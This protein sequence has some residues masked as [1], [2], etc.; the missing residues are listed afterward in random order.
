MSARASGI[1]EQW[2]EA[3]HPSEHGDVID[4]DPTLGQQL[5]DIAIGEPVAEIPPQ[6]ENDD[7]GREPEPSKRRP[8]ERG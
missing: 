8:R 6:G 4:L 7:L 2:C 5:L 3:L 1:G